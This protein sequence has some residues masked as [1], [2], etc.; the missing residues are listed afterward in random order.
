MSTVYEAS[1]ELHAKHRGKLEIRSK[2]EVKSIE[3]LSLAYSPG[4]A[5]PCKEI[6]ADEE[7]SYV[8]TNRG[9][10]VAVVSD[11]TAVLGLGN[12][13]PCA[14]LPVMEGKS[15]LFKQFANID[16]IP[17][18][19]DSK[20]PQDV[21]RFCE[22]IAPTFGGILLEDIKAP[23]CVEI[24]RT[25][26]EK[27]QIPVFHD[28]QHG[29]AI[30][31]IAAI[32]NTLRLTK[33]KVET[34]R[35]VVSGAGAAGSSIMKLMKDFGIQHIEAFDKDGQIR[36]SDAHAYDFL[37]KELLE[38][39]NLDGVHYAN[40]A[41]AMVGADIFVGVSAP[42]L[43]TK[44]M[45]ASMNKQAAVFAMANPT[46]EIMPEDALE[47]GALIVGSGRSDYPNQVNNV[48]AFPGLFKGV[49][50]ANATCIDESMK[51]AAARALAG[52]IQDEELQPNYIIPS[53][54]DPRV[55]DAI[56]S[57]VEAIAKAEGLVRNHA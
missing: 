11:G 43:V 35:V 54:F 16:A 8:Y 28:D 50:Q 9:N 45:V 19:I 53:P 6:V 25:L 15:I 44:A 27:L 31:T 38:C 18:C 13:G 52:L 4:V 1:K 7:N 32:I 51:I 23:E 57:E 56:A 47:A 24:E 29:T 20:S 5:Q 33:K 41:E 30:I 36:Q 49:L 42:N 17:L 40:L 21:I 37:K 55:V 2:V 48:L 12:I 46:P 22:M 26:K 34:L 14:A 10:S 39:V 3:D